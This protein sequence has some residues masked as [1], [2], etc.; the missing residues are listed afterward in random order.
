MG[1]KIPQPVGVRGGTNGVEAH[2]DEI[3]AM[4]RLFGK[5]ATDTGGA[6]LALHGYLVDPVTVTSGCSTR[7]ERPP[8]KPTCW[9][10]WTDTTA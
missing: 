4:A 8:S 2:Y 9:T 10:P 1:P 5:V 6:A 7:S 3:V